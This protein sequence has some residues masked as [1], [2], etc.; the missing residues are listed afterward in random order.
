[1][2]IDIKVGSV[3]NAQRSLHILKANGYRASIKKLEHPTK[4]DGCGY[5]VRMDAANETPIRLLEQNGIKVTG[6]ERV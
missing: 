5:V 4:A 6:V 3:T 1:M 2:I